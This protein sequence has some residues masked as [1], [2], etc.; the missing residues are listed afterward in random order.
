M[1]F[2]DL[3]ANHVVCTLTRGIGR[4]LQECWSTRDLQES[5][6]VCDSRLYRFIKKLSGFV[7][8]ENLKC[9]INTL[10]LLLTQILP[11][12][13]FFMLCFTRGLRLVKE[14]HICFH[15]F[16]GIVIRLCRV[17]QVGFGSSFFIFLALTRCLQLVVFF[18]QRSIQRLVIVVMV[19]LIQ[20]STL[21]VAAE[22]EV[23]VRKYTLDCGGLRCIP[24]LCRYELGQQGHASMRQS[25]PGRQ[26]I[27]N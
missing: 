12:G 24:S 2:P 13:P 6:R 25:V 22:G 17:G 11:C 21:E 15:L 1:R 23:H 18:L 3:R 16:L 20:S 9:L 10:K 26:H 8:C 7:G 27:E 14:F 5:W 4:V 19:C